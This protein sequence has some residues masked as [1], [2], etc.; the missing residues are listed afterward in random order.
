[1]AVF[2]SFRQSRQPTALCLRSGL[3][4][5]ASIFFGLICAEGPAGAANSTCSWNDATANWTVAADWSNCNSTFPNN[6]GGNTYDVVIS[7]GI[8]T[9]SSGVNPHIITV[10]SVTITNTGTLHID[11]TSGEG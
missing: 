10:G 8:P 9:I 3:S 1:M 2:G 5:A 7:Q 4:A 6:G 11:T